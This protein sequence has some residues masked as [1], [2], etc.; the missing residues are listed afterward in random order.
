MSDRDRAR[1]ER[2]ARDIVEGRLCAVPQLPPLPST[3]EWKRITPVQLD[4]YIRKPTPLGKPLGDITFDEL[5]LL[6]AIARPVFELRTEMLDKLQ[7]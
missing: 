3:P 7:P 1:V 5:K 4:E 6:H 2:I